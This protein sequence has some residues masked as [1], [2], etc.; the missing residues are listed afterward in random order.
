MEE[1]NIWN[2]FFILFNILA[3][4]FCQ[5][6]GE[7]RYGWLRYGSSCYYFSDGSRDWVSAAVSVLLLNTKIL[8]SL[9]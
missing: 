3:L 1:R 7:C 2:V 5:V 4:L 6:F 8:V 9:A